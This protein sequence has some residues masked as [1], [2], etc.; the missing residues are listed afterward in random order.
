[1]RI[2]LHETW[3]DVG[4]LSEKW[5]GLL[6]DSASNT[7]FLTWEWLDAWWNNYGSQRPLFVLSAWEGDAL[8]G[9]APFY[10]D[11]LAR[12]GRNWKCLKLI[13]DGS[14]DSDYL[15]CIARNGRENE[16]VGEFV[17]FLE[18]QRNR[19]D[20]LEFH[21]TP[22]NSPCLKALMAHVRP[23]AWRF[24]SEAIPCATLPLPGD[25]N[26]YLKLLK[27]RFRTQV[28]STMNYYDEKIG[29]LPVQCEASTD[30]ERWLPILFDLH[31]RRWQSKDMPG[32]FGE[33]AKQNF[34]R[35]VSKATLSKGWLAFH[36]LD[37]G[38]RPL[39]MQYGF[40][41]DNRFFLLQEGY[42]PEF[43]TLR[44]G[45]ALRGSLI[46][47]WI[48][49]GLAE[50][51]F[52]AGS[53]AY[54]FEWGGQLKQSVRFTL[55]PAWPAAWVS[56]GEAQAI[57]KSKEA[58]RAMLPES[59]LAWRKERKDAH[60]G[61]K[62]PALSV[63]TNGHRSS[64]GR[65]VMTSL[66]AST[67]L[68]SIG[69]AIAS[70]YE[71]DLAH[72]RLN[73]RTTP[74]CQIFIFH[75]VNDDYDPFLPSVPVAVFRKQMEFLRQNFPIISLDEVASGSYAESGEKYSV[76]ITFDDGYRDNFLKAFPVL[77]KLEMPATI[78]LATGSIQSSELPW[79]DQISWAFKLTTR[80]RFS[81]ADV[82][83][84]EANLNQRSAVLQAMGNTLAWLRTIDDE[85]RRTFI[86]RI[87]EE[88]GV[89]ARLSVPNPM[90]SWDEIKQMSKQ[91]ITFGAHTISHPALS[92]TNSTRLET[93][94]MGSKNKIEEAL[95]LPVRHFAYP[96]GQPSDVSDEAKKIVQRSGFSS[97]VTTVWGFNR[98]GDDLY[99]LKRFSPRSNAWDSDLAKMAMKLDWYRLAGLHAGQKIHVEAS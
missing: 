70:R 58:I 21:G 35:D 23:K 4:N 95:D 62:P 49:S 61:Q 22:E 3:D 33:T 94:I 59:I 60:T 27:P 38:E 53:S 89:S 79:Y 32:V 46:R 91:K 24:S 14:H 63:T 84:P 9:I 5:N 90:L 83:G 55:S 56:F 97:A 76:A 81:L 48:D 82:G 99:D 52:L 15:D 73:R 66:Y 10:L 67:A 34:Y 80:P 69:R 40:R 7:I 6:T 8:E 31:T 77:N 19:W 43:A 50:Y 41:Y 44:P 11:T 2:L 96:F 98:P 20:C 36:R 71:L 57:E 72:T 17:R 47:H 92:R 16:I 45:M 29:A 25:W 75:R 68:G 86:P 51:D 65:R 93:E 85:K 28:R 26:Q 39:A 30:I 54:K 74:I 42:D 13:G 87:F 12:W 18:S 64:L 78:F 1:M 88:L 37:W